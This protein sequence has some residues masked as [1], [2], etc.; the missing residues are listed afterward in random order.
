MIVVGER[1]KLDA[2]IVSTA[3]RGGEFLEKSE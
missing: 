2:T 3:E 1:Y